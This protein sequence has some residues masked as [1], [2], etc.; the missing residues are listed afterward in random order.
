MV[1]LTLC[2]GKR[3]NP[4]EKKR[5]VNESRWKGIAY[6]SRFTAQ[7]MGRKKQPMKKYRLARVASSGKV[8]DSKLTVMIA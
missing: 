3:T 2:S 8:R 6:Q 7:N 1:T 5:G 4:K